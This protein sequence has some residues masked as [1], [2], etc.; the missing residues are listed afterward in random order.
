MTFLKGAKKGQ[1]FSEKN[2]DLYL[3]DRNCV[4]YRPFPLEAP[5]NFVRY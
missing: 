5:L 3:S 2:I 1:V 4:V